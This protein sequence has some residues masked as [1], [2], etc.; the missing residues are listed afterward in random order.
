MTFVRVRGFK[1]FSDRH[2]KPRCYHRATGQPVDLHA[3]PIG[4]AE[5]LAEC[6]RIAA[7]STR[8]V[9]ARPGTL[10]LLITRYRSHA[11]FQDLAP[12]TRADYQKIF[13]YLRPIVDTPLSRFNAPLIVKIR[14]KAS[15]KHGRRFA[16]YV[17][18][19]LSLVFG[20]GVERG[21]LSS[22]PAASIRALKRAKG[23]PEAN[24]P[25]SDAERDA[26]WQALPLH[27]LPVV[28]LMMCTGLDPQDAVALPRSAIKDGMIDTTRGKTGQPVWLPLP[29]P[30][31]DAIAAA[32]PHDAITVC[33]SSHGR[34]WTGGGFRAS[35]RPIRQRLEAEGAVQPGLTLK[36]LR[37]TVATMLRELGYDNRTIADFLGQKTEAMAAH[38]S[39]RA[40]RSQKNTATMVKLS[41]EM[42]R[43]RTKTVKP[44]GKS[45][46]PDASA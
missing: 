31:R 12:R 46:K 35:W 1:I 38:Y 22:N 3:F 36:G 19:V 42:D 18:T 45:V 20:W 27:M 9:E 43:R 2:G 13:D 26:V 24:R 16:N 15:E 4:S 14:D 11:A 17:K 10:G 44:A 28:A 41:A 30:V 34:P 37:H 7:L 6:A 39:R 21:H 25:W 8:G 33:A 23:A 40:D 29:G 5:F 32:P